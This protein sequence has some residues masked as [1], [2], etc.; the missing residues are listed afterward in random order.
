MASVP[1]A[2]SKG[3]FHAKIHDLAS[4]WEFYGYEKTSDRGQR[5]SCN[6]CPLRL[7]GLQGPPCQWPARRARIMEAV[8]ACRVEPIPLHGSFLFPLR[9]SGRVRTVNRSGRSLA[10]SSDHASGVETGAPARARG[11]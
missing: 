6:R 3:T 11:E 10:V 8:I 9:R 1:A 2:V 7:Y 5:L 4:A